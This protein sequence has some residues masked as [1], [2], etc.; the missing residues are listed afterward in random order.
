MDNIKFKRIYSSRIDKRKTGKDVKRYSKKVIME[1]FV[2]AKNL[3]NFNVSVDEVFLTKRIK[4]LK[5]LK[6]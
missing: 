2:G 3:L 5:K 4:V 1:G 6:F